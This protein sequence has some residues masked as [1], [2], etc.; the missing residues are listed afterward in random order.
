MSAQFHEQAIQTLRCLVYN[1]L[2]QHYMVVIQVIKCSGMKFPQKP[3]DYIT[4]NIYM[5]VNDS[6][7]SP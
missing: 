2:Y 6:E 5:N 1:S 4:C 3:F 7:M